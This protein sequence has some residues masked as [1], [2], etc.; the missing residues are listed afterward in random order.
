MAFRGCQ[1]C[2]CV[3]DAQLIRNR[4]RRGWLTPERERER[5]RISTLWQEMG[6]KWTST[7]F[8]EFSS[9]QRKRQ[10]DALAHTEIFGSCSDTEGVTF[11]CIST[12]LCAYVCILI[13][14]GFFF[15]C[16]QLHQ[17]VIYEVFQRKLNRL[18]VAS[19]VNPSAQPHFPQHEASYIFP[20]RWHRRKTR[21]DCNTCCRKT[22]KP[23]HPCCESQYGQKKKRSFSCLFNNEAESQWRAVTLTDVQHC[24]E[25]KAGVWPGR[26][27]A[28]AHP[29][30]YCKLF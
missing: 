8:S 27:A 20:D 9:I 22:I 2:V 30:Y 17:W 26:P 7:A 13:R 19:H 1:V 11:V 3:F 24:N 18:D 28:C 29:L 21:Q 25:V 4:W 12:L 23:A 14:V 5:W 6:K 15:L 16:W 10:P